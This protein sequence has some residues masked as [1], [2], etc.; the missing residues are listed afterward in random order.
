[1]HTHYEQDRWFGTRIK[2]RMKTNWLKMYDKF[3]VILRVETVINCPK[4]FS[5]YRTRHHHGGTSSVGYYPMTKSVASLVHYQE[6]AI[7]CNRRYLD[8]LAVVDDPTPAYQDLRELTE[9]K[10]VEGR[11]YAG[12]NPAR[13]EDVRLFAA[14]LSGDHVARGFRN[15]DIR[16][17]LFGCPKQLSLERR[18]SAAVGRL[19]KRMHVRHLVAK[20]PRTRRWRITQRGR[21]LL[22]LTLQ[23]YKNSWP[24]LAA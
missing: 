21:H 18:A 4:E 8:A 12:F 17:L 24:E 15:R 16:E 20:I 1:V 10:V 22:G 3:G 11:S 9:P 19:F 13:R 7:A 6:Q 5:V 14:V 2:H 23:L